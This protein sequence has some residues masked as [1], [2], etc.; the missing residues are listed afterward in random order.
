MS[1]D[2]NCVARVAKTAAQLLRRGRLL[3]KL[4][5]R[6]GWKAEE[7]KGGCVELAQTRQPHCANQS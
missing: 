7:A 6:G 3:P 2:T 4:G 5:G 1:L